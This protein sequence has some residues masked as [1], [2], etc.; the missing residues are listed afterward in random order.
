MRK[1]GL[2]DTCS[3][4][5]TCARTRRV[6][7]QR[8]KPDVHGLAGVARDGDA[9]GD[10]RARDAEVPQ[11]AAHPAQHLVAP[12]S[13][14]HKVGVALYQLLRARSVALR[15]QLNTAGCLVSAPVGFQ[16]LQ[17]S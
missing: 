9:P 8:V 2:V 5:E 7:K 1:S 11:P 16:D 12:R 10:G 3:R 14:L 15:L 6:A 17:C 4:C 13:R